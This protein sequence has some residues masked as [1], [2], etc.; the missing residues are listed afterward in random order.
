ML[1]NLLRLIICSVIL[2][3]SIL[4]G[5]FSYFFSRNSRIIACHTFS[6]SDD[7][8]RKTWDFLIPLSFIIFETKNFRSPYLWIMPKMGK[9]REHPIA[10]TVGWFIGN[11]RSWR[12]C[13]LGE[14][15]LAAETLYQF[16]LTIP[17]A[18]QAN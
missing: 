15:D 9:K 8:A 3:F 10:R 2:G 13:V 14:W 5:V 1:R 7:V 4:L 18:T 17:P 11:L 6:W 12:Y 16:N